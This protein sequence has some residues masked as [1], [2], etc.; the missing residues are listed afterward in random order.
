MVG[1]LAGV[2][3]DLI[4]VFVTVHDSD[5]RNRL[6][7]SLSV[8]GGQLIKPVRWQGPAKSSYKSRL[9]RIETR[10]SCWLCLIRRFALCYMFSRG[11]VLKQA[12]G[13]GWGPA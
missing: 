8:L 6:L 13:R 11:M 1:T 4:C 7:S 9:L 12:V 5:F 2:D 3:G 10:G